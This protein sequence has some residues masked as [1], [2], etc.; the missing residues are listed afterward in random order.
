V[1]SACAGPVQ[2]SQTHPGPP[3]VEQLARQADVVVV[4]DV[5][6][7]AGEWNAARTNIYTRVHLD[8]REFLK[9][10]APAPLSFTQLGGRVGEQ[11]SAIGGA[12]RFK[13]GERVLVFLARGP[14][15]AL[16]LS[17]LIHGKFQIERDAATG[18]EYAVRF[19]GAPGADRFALD[20]VR[21]L[22]RR[23]L[24]S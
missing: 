22:V 12:A 1:L 6:A 3:T 5:T 24:G 9:G 17:D 4:G 15:G 20:Q 13:A 18:R 19:T 14:D 21:A 10:T 8:A 16:R 11:M 2:A 23:T 7:A